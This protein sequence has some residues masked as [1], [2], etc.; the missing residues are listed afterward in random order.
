MKLFKCLIRRARNCP[1]LRLLNR[2]C[3]AE[4]SAENTRIGASTKLKETGAVNLS[5]IGSEALHFKGVGNDSEL[6]SKIPIDRAELNKFCC[7]KKQV[8]SFVWAVCRRVVPLPLL[9]DEVSNWRIL[10]K[11][12][13]KFIELRKFEKFSLKEC[14]HRLKTSKFRLFS[15]YMNNAQSRGELGYRDTVRHAIME[16]WIFWLFS[17]LVSPL[18]QANFYVT[19]SGDEKLDVLYYVKSIWEKLIDEGECMK[20]ERFYKLS[21]TSAS[22]ILQNRM[23]G[24]SRVRICPKRVGFRMFTNLKA[25]SRLPL[26]QCSKFCARRKLRRKEF[27]NFFAE[28]CC[29]RGR[30][31]P[32]KYRYFKPVNRV[33]GDIHVVLK[34]LSRTDSFT[35]GS[36]VFDYNGVYRKLVPFLLFLRER[37]DT[38][39]FIV[40][41]DVSKA[42]DSIDHQKL[43][44]VVEDVVLDDEYALEEVAKVVCSKRRLKVQPL[45]VM[46]ARRDV[47]NASSGKSPL[48]PTSQT[49]DAVFIT[50]RTSRTMRREEAIFNI[51]EHI[52]RNVVL[53]RDSFYLQRVGIPQGG[54][55]SPLLCSFYYD[56]MERN[57][58]SPLMEKA[59]RG[60]MQSS[61][62]G[63]KYVL[64]RF[65]DDFL[66]IS[67]S[68]K[69]AS[70]FL[71]RLGRGVRDYNCYMNAEKSGLNF[72]M[73]E[74]GREVSRSS[75]AHVGK[76]GVS[77]LR[78]SGLL[79]NCATLEIQAD[80]R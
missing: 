77:F 51:K 22:K 26:G 32:V 35:T 20:S 12:I 59:G 70:T 31:H 71:T 42:Y 53:F 56:H 78:W 2:H 45:R 38:L 27:S 62:G 58:F 3:L 19:D 25:P 11:N 6:K 28:S 75:R 34:G 76:D 13:S 55:L 18:I 30:N 50:K 4:F 79:V 21:H 14:I 23:F 57:V 69:Q 44:R 16:R 80:Y 8:V 54:I 49:S 5:R 29:S 40:V 72:T 60:A 47:A 52:T 39:P 33:L 9:G 73:E 24:F 41:S 66:F 63:S 7:P 46:A 68:K 67:N 17:H 65:V 15:N 1:Y 74:D 10:T 37:P 64:L 48:L 43:L 61:P 36:S